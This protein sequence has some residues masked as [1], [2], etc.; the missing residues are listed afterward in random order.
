MRILLTCAGG[1]LVS[2][3]FKY[4]KKDKNLSD[5]FIAGIDKKKIKK[6]KFLDKF[7]RI[8]FDNNYLKKIIKICYL[9]KIKLIIPYSDKE[10]IYLSK[11]KPFLIKKGIFLLT[12][13]FKTNKKISN[14]YAVYEKLKKAGLRVPKYFIF[15]S[16]NQFNLY[17]KILDFPN[18]TVV[19][20]PLDGIGG[21][22]V[23]FLKGKDFRKQKWVGKGKREKTLNIKNFKIFKHLNTYKKLIIMERLNAPAY[24]V[25][26]FNHKTKKLVSIRKRLNPSGIPYKGNVIVQNKEIENYCNKIAKIIGINNLVDFDILHNSKKKIVLLEIN[27]RPSGSIVVNHMAKFPFL[28]FVIS[29]VLKKNYKIKKLKVSKII[30]I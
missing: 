6:N 20:K 24:D 14:K 4:L 23:I 22:G 10:S 12:N 13:D 21:R 26:Y 19:V 17:L 29:A 3:T 9:N 7:Y 28:S 11:K 15:N 8:N 5:L 1:K 27:P 25:D 2:K 18:K 30:K 16:V